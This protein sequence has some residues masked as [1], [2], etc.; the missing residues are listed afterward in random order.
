ML[1]S[2]SPKLTQAHGNAAAKYYF[3]VSCTALISCVMLNS[4]IRKL[5]G[6]KNVASHVSRATFRLYSRPSRL[7]I[8][9]VLVVQIDLLLIIPPYTRELEQNLHAS[10]LYGL[11]WCLRGCGEGIGNGLLVSTCYPSW[12]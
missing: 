3:M 12:G 1:M 10:R 2:A 5:S 11:N 4:P 7:S 6:M 9:D 8:I